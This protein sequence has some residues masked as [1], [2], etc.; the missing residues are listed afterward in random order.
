MENH[1]VLSICNLFFICCEGRLQAKCKRSLGTTFEFNFE[2][3]VS[4]G[5]FG[6]APQFFAITEKL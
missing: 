3:T 5:S 4:A 6:A 2:W 1:K